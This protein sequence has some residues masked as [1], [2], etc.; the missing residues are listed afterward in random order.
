MRKSRFTQEQIIGV[1]KEHHA[2]LS[3]GELCRKH[4][5][6]DAACVTS[7]STSTCSQAISRPNTSSK[8]GGMTTITTDPT[9]ASKGSHQSSL[10]TGPK[11]TKT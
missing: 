10:Q 8:H 3:A 2:G 5:I 1:L 4:G 11:R 6:S 9:A 7:A